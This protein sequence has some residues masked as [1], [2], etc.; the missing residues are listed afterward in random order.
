M[1]AVD[2]ATLADLNALLPMVASYRVFYGQEPDEE[3]ERALILEH[4]RNGTSTIY[5][6][7]DEHGEAL[8]FAQLF[9]TQS[10]V[11]LGPSLVLED[12]F[13]VPHARRAGVATKLLDRAILHAREVGATGMFLET[14]M[15]NGVAQRL[16]ERAGWARETQFYKYNAPL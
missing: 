10:T 7:R 4:L 9:Q 2:C 16:Y 6:A 15:D 1:I 8:G 12:L 14:A 11:R 13:V 3:R 5:L